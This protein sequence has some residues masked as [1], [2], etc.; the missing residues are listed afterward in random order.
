[1]ALGPHGMRMELLKKNQDIMMIINWIKSG[2]TG[3]KMVEKQVKQVTI[4]DLKMAQL[5]FGMLIIL[6]F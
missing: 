4:R 5:Y 1:M 3:Q 6:K 2:P